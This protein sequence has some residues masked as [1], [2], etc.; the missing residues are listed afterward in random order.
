MYFSAA[1]RCETIRGRC[2][3][4]GANYERIGR[5]NLSRLYSQLP[6]NLEGLLRA[7]KEAFSFFCMI[8]KKRRD[9]K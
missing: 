8:C 2:R 6:A 4:L 7:E 3:F 1:I 5:D 9:G